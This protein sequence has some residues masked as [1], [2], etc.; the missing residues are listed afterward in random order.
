MAKKKKE[1]QAISEKQH[2]TMIPEALWAIG[3]YRRR[4]KELTGVEPSIAASINA[5]VIMGERHSR[6]LEVRTDQK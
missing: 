6:N 3:E 2:I 4:I 5:L 1:I